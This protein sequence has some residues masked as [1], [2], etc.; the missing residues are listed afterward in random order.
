MLEIILIC[1]RRTKRFRYLAT[2][3]NNRRNRIIF[4][5][6]LEIVLGSAFPAASNSC[7][8]RTDGGSGN[9][10]CSFN[11]RRPSITKVSASLF[12]QKQL[13]MTFFSLPL[14]L[15]A[16]PSSR[17]RISVTSSDIHSFIE[18][19]SPPLH[20]IRCPLI[21]TIL[22][23]SAVIFLFVQGY[24]KCYSL[25]IIKTISKRYGAGILH[26]VDSS[27]YNM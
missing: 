19:Y 18:P 13:A 10:N 5:G 4:N 6:F 21:D 25:R 11:R 16:F 1:L 23:N 27:I 9:S 20:W 2:L 12:A 26:N 8:D 7:S 22:C 14:L 24:D 3:K 17:I 15:F